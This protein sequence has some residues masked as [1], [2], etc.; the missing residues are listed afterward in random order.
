MF[1]GLLNRPPDQNCFLFLAFAHLAPNSVSAFLLLSHLEATGHAFWR[2]W[3]NCR[4]HL[5]L[6]S[7]QVGSGG[8]GHLNGAHCDLG[9]GAG[10][11][12]S[13]HAWSREVLGFSKA[14]MTHDPVWAQI[15]RFYLLRPIN[16]T[17]QNGNSPVLRM[18]VALVGK[19]VCN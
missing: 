8:R 11:Y 1:P 14:F 5:W 2:F 18:N 12:F 7:Q 19:A 6:S 4:A 16:L 13:R 15:P 17:L 3:W 9:L 10:I